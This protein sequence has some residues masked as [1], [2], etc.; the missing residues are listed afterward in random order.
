MKVALMWDETWRR[1]AEYEVEEWQVRDAFGLE[2][3]EPI[4]DAHVFGYLEGIESDGEGVP[5]IDG[6]LEGADFLEWSLLCAEES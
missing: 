1:T 5:W 3:H 4:N 6:K 2:D